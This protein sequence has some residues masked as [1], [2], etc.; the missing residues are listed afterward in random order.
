MKQIQK[1][2]PII[3]LIVLSLS[4]G[5]SS[6]S[7]TA[8]IPDQDDKSEIKKLIYDY[9]D[10]RYQSGK[11]NID[12]DFSTFI[13]SN[14]NSINAE[15]EKLKLENYINRSKN[16]FYSSYKFDLEFADFQI[17]EEKNITTVILYES[18]DVIYNFSLEIDKNDPIVTRSR[19]LMHEIKLTKTETDWKISSDNYEDLF[20]QF[21]HGSGV[22]LNEVKNIIDNNLEEN[23]DAQ[24]LTNPS[25]NLT[26]DETSHEYNR[27]SA[28]NYARNWALSRN[29]DYYNFEDFDCTNF[30][31]Q[32]IHE[33]SLA[34]MSDESLSGWYYYD[35][36]DR[37]VAWTDVD[38]FHVFTTHEYERDYF[39]QSGPEGCDLSSKYDLRLGDIVQFDLEID[40]ENVFEHS[41]I[42]TA[43]EY[44]Y[45]EYFYYFSAHSDNYV[46][47]PLDSVLTY[48][49]RRFIR[50]ER[51]DGE[52]QF[53][54][55]P[56]IINSSENTLIS[57]TGDD[58]NL[59]NQAY[60]A[61]GTSLINPTETTRIGYP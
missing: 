40:N 35:I 1:I 23:Y 50:I 11:T 48:L 56:N 28:V 45:G 4:I 14:S 41:V 54:Y 47:K 61:P 43:M 52:I 55:L 44:A 29:P 26:Y 34:E 19:G 51:I 53:V 59:D 6:I 13:D 49:D 24:V 2:T 21:I 30:I 39:Y 12:Q 60:P 57:I 9:F 17:D 7:A 42:I 8:D 32:A 58:L 37:G 27:Y 5:I 38:A 20:W 46:D 25:C 33:G 15:I 31:S 36:Y 16:I 3:L 22:E 18:S 10:T